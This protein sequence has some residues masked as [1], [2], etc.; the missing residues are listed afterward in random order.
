MR[1]R[2]RPVLG[3]GLG[4]PHTG[5]LTAWLRLR[6]LR[7]LSGVIA[8]STRGAAEYAAAGIPVGRIYVAPH[9]V[10]GPPP[11]TPAAASGG[12]AAVISGGRRRRRRGVDDLLA[13]CAVASPAPE[14]WIVGDG[15]DRRRL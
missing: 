10:E 4:A 6:F 9:A 11:R 8:Y 5:V 13:A 14:L 15:P 2:R 12:R 7:G 3:W 1:W